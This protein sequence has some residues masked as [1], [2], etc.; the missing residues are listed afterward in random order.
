MSNIGV[1]SLERKYEAAVKQRDFFKSVLKVIAKDYVP[2]NKTGRDCPCCEFD[3]FMT[4]KHHPECIYVLAHNPVKK[5]S[6]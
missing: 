2:E 5:K 1:R 4:L 6:K 3:G